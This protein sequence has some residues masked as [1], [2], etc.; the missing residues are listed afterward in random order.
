MIEVNGYVLFSN[1]REHKNDVV[2][3]MWCIY[4]RSGI[5]AQAI[6]DIQIPDELECCWVML[7]P[8]RIPRAVSPIAVCCVFLQCHLNELMDYLEKKHPD[9]KVRYPSK[10]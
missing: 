7:Q 8:K 1:C 10:F 2:Y 6:M 5:D 3:V 4:V 9:N